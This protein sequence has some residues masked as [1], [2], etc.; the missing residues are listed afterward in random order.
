MQTD[1]RMLSLNVLASTALKKSYQFRGSADPAPPA[2]DEADDY[3]GSLQTVLE[4]IMLLLMIPYKF[5]ANPVMPKKWR[6]IGQAGA[7]FQRFISKMLDDET[8][9]LSEGKSGSGG[10]LTGCAQA[11]EVHKQEEAVGT[12]MKEKKG[13]SAAEICGNLFVTNF[14]G[15]DATFNT[16]S[17]TILLLIAHPEI[18]EWVA[19]EVVAVTGGKPAQE[20]DYKALYPRLKRCRAV[21]LETLRI[22]PSFPIVPKVSSSEV[23]TLKVGEQTLVIPPNTNISASIITLQSHPAY[24]TD[25]MSWKPERWIVNQGASADRFAN[26]ELWTPDRLIYVPWSDG[27]MSCLGRKAAEVELTGAVA[28]LLARNR[29]AA[30]PEFSG[31]SDKEIRARVGH[32]V[33]DTGFEMLLAMKNADSVRVVCREA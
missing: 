17:F 15:H 19:E 9:A 23:Q 20:W 16:L 30:Q 29:L 13:L 24:W 10:L 27:P 26:E 14:A 33:K 32:V 11:L 6:R 1:V 8:Q 31:E 25:P 21:L 5:L 4:N 2:Q 22:Y 18:Q 28:C 3:R 12:P 7:S